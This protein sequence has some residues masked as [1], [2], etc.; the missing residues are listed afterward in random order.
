MADEDGTWST[1]DKPNDEDTSQTSEHPHAEFRM[2]LWDS[3]PGGKAVIGV[4]QEGEFVW[5][6]S[7]EHVSEQARDELVEQLTRIVR[8]GLWI[9]NWPGR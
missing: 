9:Q 8:E 6:A 1:G 4:E 3:L 5:I 7:R 2:E